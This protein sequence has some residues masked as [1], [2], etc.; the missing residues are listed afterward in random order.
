MS[1]NTKQPLSEV[2]EQALKNYQQALEAGLKA[3]EETAKW[4]TEF[5]AQEDSP[6]DWHK[7]WS[8]AAIQ[9][10]PVLQKRMEESLRLLD[11]SGRSSLELLKQACQLVGSDS[12][13]SAQQKMGDLWEASLQALRKNALTVSQANAK[14]MESWMNLFSS[15][16]GPAGGGRKTT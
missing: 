3:Q 4:W 1:D 8:T 9:M 15:P 14:A 12:A 10:I 13:T 11:Q 6:A 7:R 2:I 16:L 5:T